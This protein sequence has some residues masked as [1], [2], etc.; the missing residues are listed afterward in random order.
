MPASPSAMR[1][2]DGAA[3][4]D[5]GTEAKKSRR[6]KM[7][8]KEQRIDKRPCEAR[9]VPIGR[10]ATEP[11]NI[12]YPERSRAD[13]KPTNLLHC[14]MSGPRCFAWSTTPRL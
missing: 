12:L 6:T 7:G 10:G 1:E 13:G 2:V 5:G 11:K 4:R 14:S 9:A 3:V 8:R